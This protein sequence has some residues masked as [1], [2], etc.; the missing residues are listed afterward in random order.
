LNCSEVRQHRVLVRLTGSRLLK[1]VA[2]PTHDGPHYSE[3][4]LW[5]SSRSK[6]SVAEQRGYSAPLAVSSLRNV[7]SATPSVGAAALATAMVR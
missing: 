7:L 1:E 4:G 2:E 5:A 3:A 6:K